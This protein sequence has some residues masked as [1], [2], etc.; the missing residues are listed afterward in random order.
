MNIKAIEIGVQK[1]IS[2]I[3]LLLEKKGNPF[4]KTIGIGFFFFL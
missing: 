4:K 2:G 3:G 1:K